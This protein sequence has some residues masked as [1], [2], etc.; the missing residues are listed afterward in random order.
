[1]RPRQAPAHLVV[2]DLPDALESLRYHATP[3]HVISHGKI[4]DRQRMAVLAGQ[5]MESPLH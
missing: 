1:M 4:V 5:E 3:A 2:L